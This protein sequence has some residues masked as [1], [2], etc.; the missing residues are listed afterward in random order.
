MRLDYNRLV[1]GYHGCDASVVEDVLLSDS[2]LKVS[3][4]K[5]DWLGEGIYFW[6]HGPARALEF[7]QEKQVREPKKVTSPAVLGAYIQLGRCFDLGDVEFTS[8]LAVEFAKFQAAFQQIGLKA[9]PKNDESRLLRYLDCAVINWYLK[10]I[11]K[12]KAP[13]ANSVY[14]ETVRGIFEEGGEAFP[15]SALQ[16]K[17]HVQIAVR[18]P[19]C[20]VGYFKPRGV[21]GLT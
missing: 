15:G 17:A 21:G 10:R 14:Y 9:L 4:N 19:D 13:N 2:E 3:N 12:E 5:Y 6:E 20:I 8:L 18:N 16:K 7:A 1:V 11:D